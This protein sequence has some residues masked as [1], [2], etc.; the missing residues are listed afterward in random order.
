MASVEKGV[1]K[2]LK[3]GEATIT[4]TT[5]DGK[6]AVQVLFDE[7][8]PKYKDRNGGYTRVTK[9]YIRRGDAAPMA[10]IELV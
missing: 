8:A 2:G 3:V 7:V 10:T 4:V 1:V 9:T 6:S 5:K